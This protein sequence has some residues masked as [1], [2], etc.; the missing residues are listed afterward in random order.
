MIREGSF[1]DTE[2][3]MHPQHLLETLESFLERVSSVAGIF[4]K[5]GTAVIITFKQ[6]YRVI[7]FNFKYCPYLFS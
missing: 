5:D 6:N 7:T 2:H 3:E 1:P 4:Y